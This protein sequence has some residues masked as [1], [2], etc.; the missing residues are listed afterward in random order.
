MKRQLCSLILL[1]A[2]GC[3]PA[4][5]QG[6]AMCWTSANAASNRGKQALNNGITLML[7]PTLGLIAG[8]VGL[9]VVYDRKRNDG[10]SSE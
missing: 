4:F 9:T 6:C 7:V 2:L 1:C 3:V 10:D 5:G 8:F